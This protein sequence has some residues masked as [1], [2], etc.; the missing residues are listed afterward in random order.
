M[1]PTRRFSGNPR[2][3]VTTGFATDN[4]GNVY[5]VENG[6][7][8][9]RKITPTGVVSTVVGQAGQLGFRPGALPGTLNS[10]YG[11][12]IFGRT[13]YATSNDGIVS[14]TNQP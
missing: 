5:V 12:V 2:H 9:I 8:T 1:T 13:L 3:P 11:L 7:T 6:N 14:V 4:T 10:V